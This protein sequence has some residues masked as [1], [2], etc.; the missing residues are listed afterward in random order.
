MISMM[1]S[2]F[3][4]RARAGSKTARQIQTTA[5]GGVSSAE[6]VRRGLGFLRILESVICVTHTHSH[7]WR[8][9]KPSRPPGSASARETP[10]RFG[11]SLA[12]Q[13]GA[14]SGIRTGRNTYFWRAMAKDRRP[15]LIYSPE[16]AD[17]VCEL[18]VEGLSLRAICEMSGMPSRQ[19]IFNWLQNNGEFR[20]KYE[21]ARLMQVE[22]WAHEIVEIAD[23]TSGDFVI[24]ERGERVVDHEN[25]N[26]ARLKIDAR[27]WL[28][29]FRTLDHYARAR[30]RTRRSAA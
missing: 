14:R 26:R 24:N 15:Y 19:S 8:A 1:R 10:E 28:T 29:R 23:D 2:R 13:P 7:T 6:Q 22:C 11:A 18:M 4:Y 9:P 27:K 25:I 16:L 3:R 5:C 21:I 20:E 17:R 30:A 12:V